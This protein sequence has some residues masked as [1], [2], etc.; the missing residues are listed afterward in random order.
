MLLRCG[1]LFHLQIVS[2]FHAR[3]WE[4]HSFDWLFSTGSDRTGLLVARL[5]TLM[6]S[7]QV[8]SVCLCL[9]GAPGFA[10]D[11]ARCLRTSHSHAEPRLALSLPPRSFCSP[12]H[13][14][15]QHCNARTHHSSHTPD[16]RSQP[17]HAP[18][19][20]GTHTSALLLRVRGVLLVAASQRPF[21]A[22]VLTRPA[23]IRSS[24]Q[25]YSPRRPPSSH[26]PEAFA[27]SLYLCTPRHHS[28][29]VLLVC[30]LPASRPLGLPRTTA[31]PAAPRVSRPRSLRI[32]PFTTGMILLRT[33]PQLA[34]APFSAGLRTVLTCSVL[35]S[36][37][38][39]DRGGKLGVRVGGYMRKERVARLFFG[40]H[41]P[42]PSPAHQ[43]L[44]PPSALSLCQTTTFVPANPLQALG[45][46]PIPFTM[47][48]PP[49]LAAQ[50]LFPKAA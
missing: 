19:H 4:H 40:V 28:N 36:R 20:L 37:L 30:S 44:T 38:P 3:D 46:Q 23:P 14:Q 48:K 22:C 35:D 32:E 13:E 27:P 1:T 9:S 33:L 7:A 41:G 34:S 45:Q 18:T 12:V 21:L 49:V 6:E 15:L 24:T 16:A 25:H 11:V 10:L 31:Q 5:L 17:T 42:P 2:S 50:P 43:I 26:A 29:P 39:G 8:R 47:H